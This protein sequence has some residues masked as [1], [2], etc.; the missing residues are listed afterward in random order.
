[1]DDR[2][3]RQEQNSHYNCILFVLVNFA[4]FA[5]L[6]TG[7]AY[8]GG[9]K[10]WPAGQVSVWTTKCTGED[11]GVGHCIAERTGADKMLTSGQSELLRNP[12][13]GWDRRS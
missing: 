1:M 6:D 5:L 13:K 8:R 10:N 3:S 4:L 9:L 7:I 12:L 2:M 11:S